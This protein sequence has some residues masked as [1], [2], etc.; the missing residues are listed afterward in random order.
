MT[1]YDFIMAA[2]EDIDR[3]FQNILKG[4]RSFS[5]ERRYRRKDGSP[6]DVWASGSVIP[7]GQREG[8]FT[9]ARD[10]TQRKQAE[11]ALR[12]SEER[13]RAVV[14][15]SVDSI[16]IVDAKTKCILDANPAFQHLLGYTAQE[17]TGLSVY[18][19]IGAHQVNID[20]RFQDILQGEGPVFYERQYRRKDGSW[21]DVGG[22]ASP[23]IFGGER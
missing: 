6:V 10:L 12:E 9:I 17:I 7:F 23:I 11:E 20:Q 16:L 18:D 8:M 1:L 2:R 21:V 15:Q 19:F 22:S 14:E 5:Y 3:R 13:F 4:Q